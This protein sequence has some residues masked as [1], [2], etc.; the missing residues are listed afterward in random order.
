VCFIVDKHKE[1]ES[2]IALAVFLIPDEHKEAER[3]YRQ[4][5]KIYNAL[6]PSPILSTLLNNLGVTLKRQYK[7]KEAQPCFEQAIAIRSRVGLMFFHQ[8]EEELTDCFIYPKPPRG[9]TLDS[10]PFCRAKTGLSYVCGVVPS[11]L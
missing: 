8:V 11:P 1:A 7:F 9:R 6:G 2:L 4:A 5:V 10:P 3:L